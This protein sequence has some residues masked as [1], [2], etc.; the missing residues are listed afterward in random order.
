MMIFFQLYRSLHCPSSN[1]ERKF[2]LD[3]SFYNLYFPWLNCVYYKGFCCNCE[4]GKLPPKFIKMS[5]KQGL[6]LLLGVLD[7]YCS[8]SAQGTR[9]CI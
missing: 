2:K 8:F 7:L 6:F 3:F 4:Y 5:V 1:R 9:N